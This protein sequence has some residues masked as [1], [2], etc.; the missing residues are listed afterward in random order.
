MYRFF[1][2]SENIS[3]GQIIIDGGD[4]NHI[5]NVLRMK[6]GERLTVS[7]GDNADYLCAIRELDGER[8]VLDI[9]E[10]SAAD[11][12]LDARIYLFQGLPKGDKMELIVQKCVELGVYEIIPVAMKRSVV[13]LD[14][15]KAE[16]KTAR[17]QAISE[18]A[19]KQSGRSAVPK[20][21]EP[22][23]FEQALEYAAEA[24]IKLMPYELARGMEATREAV[25]AVH[26]GMNVAVFIGPE[27]G[28]EADEAE[29]AKERGAVPVSLGRRILRTETAGLAVMAVLMYHLE[30][31]HTN[32]SVS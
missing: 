8:I 18:S 2:K 22:M 31:E 23:T 17:W 1:G 9:L 24:D 30:Q 19:A 10:K 15:K 26:K 3:D 32:G 13:R 28:F 21:C 14:G 7:G 27:G 4:V 11:K 29:A 25:E 12:E 5:R 20:V 16:A 6:P